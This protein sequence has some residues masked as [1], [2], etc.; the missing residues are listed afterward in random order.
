MAAAARGPTFRARHLAAAAGLAWLAG[1]S[2]LSCAGG[3]GVVTAPV[4]VPRSPEVD[5]TLFLIGDAGKPEAGDPVLAALARLAGVAPSRSTVVFLGDNIYPAGLPDSTDATRPETERRL[6]AQLE[7]ATRSGAPAIMLPGNHDWMEG[8]EGGWEAVRRQERMVVREGQG[9]VE[10]LPGDGCPGPVVRDLGNSLRV[11]ALD[12]QWWLHRGPKPGDGSACGADTREEVI[13]GLQA[14]LEGAGGR[15]VV[16]AGH[17][18][19][20]SGGRHGGYFTPRQ[21]LFP[22]TEVASWAWLPLPVIGSLYPAARWLG[23][24]SQDLTSRGYR[25]LV[26]SFDSATAGRQPLAW[27][28]GHEHTLQVLEGGA[29][30]YQLVSGTG[31]WGHA[32][33]AGWLDR[34]RYASSRGGFMRIDV[35]A[36]GRIRLGVVEVAAD[37]SDREGFSMYLRGA[38][39]RGGGPRGPFSDPAV[40]QYLDMLR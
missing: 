40:A 11:V 16:V 29:A 5:W 17:H 31:Y 38:V 22:L 28:G 8:R 33:D 19:L 30:R 37:G 15:A 3:P 20:A 34:T 12:T 7:V 27:A 36:D 39:A 23:I 13:A 2:L 1:V 18:P 14:A 21:H 4:P 6:R 25:A 32:S 35:L 10:Y 24:S 26:A 9:L